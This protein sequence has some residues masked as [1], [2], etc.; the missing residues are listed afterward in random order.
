[1]EEF[2]KNCIQLYL[3]AFPGESEAFTAA[4]FDR[5]FPDCIRTI[6]EDGKPVSM[7]FSIPYPMICEDGTQKEAHYLYGVATHPDHRGKGLAKQLLAAEAARYPVFL[8]PMTPS[9]FD[10][11][12]KAGFSPISPIEEWEEDAAPGDE[13]CR[14]LSAKEY[15]ISREYLAPLPTCAPTETFL[16]LYENGG[17]FAEC[18]ED[19]AALYE[20][21]GDLILFKEFWGSTHLAPRLAGF[22]GGKRFRLRRYR[23]AGDPFG[24]GVGLPAETAFLAALD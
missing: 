5:Y 4:L 9:L 15:L 18:G 1:M 12:K 6:C 11:Y 10:F 22:L 20:K 8:R 21:Q 19:A 14:H 2:K 17:G 23:P 16:S 13:H 7:L 3:G 24:V